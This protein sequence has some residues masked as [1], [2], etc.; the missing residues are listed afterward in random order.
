MVES[1]SMLLQNRCEFGSGGWTAKQRK[2]MEGAMTLVR[3][4]TQREISA[5]GAVSRECG[6]TQLTFPH[7]WGHPS[8]P[9]HELRPSEIPFQEFKQCGEGQL[10]PSNM[11]ADNDGNQRRSLRENVAFC[12]S[13]A[14]SKRT[15]S[16]APK[17][18]CR[19]IEKRECVAIFNRNQTSF[20]KGCEG[21]FE[22]AYVSD[23][24]K[25]TCATIL[26]LKRKN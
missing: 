12:T 9:G 22:S 7:S 17:G 10:L 1:H 6:L 8:C 2:A 18:E 16:I 21:D 24:G 13:L 3:I 23:T 26:R 20:L 14:E 15:T 5:Q 11:R 4:V 19:P 25:R